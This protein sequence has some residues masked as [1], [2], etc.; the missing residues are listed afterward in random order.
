MENR[1]FDT[2]YINF[3]MK[4]YLLFFFA[5]FFVGIGFSQNEI[6]KALQK[7]NS[8]S[9]PYISSEDLAKMDS[10][11][12]LDTRKEEEYRI[13]HLKNAIWVGYKTFDANTIFETI[14]DKKMPI[15]VYCSIGVRS[16][17]IGEKLI[18]AGYTNVSNLYGGIFDWK[19]KGYPVYN[20]QQQETN[21]VHAFDKQWGKLLTNGEKVY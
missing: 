10:P 4:P 19:N 16:E 15:V 2:H 9:V 21:K 18:A 3:Q 5:L 12:L 14:K 11:I 8:Q 13:S 20:N 6:D 1:I 7:Y 17:D